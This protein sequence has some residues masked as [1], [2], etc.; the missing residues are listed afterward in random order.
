MKDMIHLKMAADGP[1]L[2]LRPELQPK[3]DL[4]T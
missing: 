1:D 3:Q 2:D 4:S